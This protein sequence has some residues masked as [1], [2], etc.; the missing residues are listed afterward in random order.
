MRL[1]TL[2]VPLVALSCRRAAPPPSAHADAARSVAV[3]ART[4]LAD[5]SSHPA[6]DASVDG[7]VLTV[8]RRSPPPGFVPRDASTPRRTTVAHVRPTDAN[9]PMTLLATPTG[10][11]F[12]RA[13]NHAGQ[14]VS[15]IVATPL[16]RRGLPVGE[17]KLVRRTT[18][19]IEA[20][21]ADARGAHV[22]IA[23]HTVRV[24]EGES[25]GEHIVAAI[26]GNADLSTVDAPLTLVDSSY[27]AS[28]YPWAYAFANVL[29]HEDGRAMV[30]SNDAPAT[31]QVFRYNSDDNPEWGPCAT[32]RISNLSPTRI[33]ETSSGAMEVPSGVP[34]A[35]VRLP[36]AIGYVVING[37]V[38]DKS[39][40]T[41]LGW[42]S[43]HFDLPFDPSVPSYDVV[44]MAWSDGVLALLMHEEDVGNDDARWGV[45]MHGPAALRGMPDLDPQ[46]MVPVPPRV[47]TGPLRCVGGHPVVRVGWEG[48]PRGGMVFDPTHEGTSIDLGSWADVDRLPRPATVTDAPYDIVWAGEALVGRVGA[49]LLRWTCASNGALRLAT[50]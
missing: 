8:R 31:C 15:E 40:I 17:P 38:Y 45:W 47:V 44:S 3:D 6:S 5:A 41:T 21:S 48:G 13:V 16:D 12:V 14:R 2:L 27:A 32:Y 43:T 23:W 28:S 35:F 46:R 50:P 1:H 34:H 29:A 19:P 42:G 24:Q 33:D 49:T 25:H 26:H 7:A 4:P 36:D 30:L 9:D 20:L 22:W 39:E 11:L 18:G 37:D 10:A